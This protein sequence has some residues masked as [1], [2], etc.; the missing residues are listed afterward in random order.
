MI[1][2]H[3]HV[4]FGLD[5]G[6]RDLEMSLQMLRALCEDGVHTV[7]CTPHVR[8]DYPTSA[9]EMEEVVAVV[10]DAAAAESLNITV[11]TG[12]ELSLERLPQLHTRERAR[13][14]LGGNPSLLLLETP[15]LVWPP[16]FPRVCARLAYEGVVPLVA[17][18]ERNP[19]VQEDPALVERVVEAG[20]MTQLTA[21]SVAGD[22]GRRTAACAHRLIE[23]ELVHVVASDSHGV[24]PRDTRMSAARKAVGS[25]ALG[26]WLTEFV[27]AALLAG[28]PIPPRPPSSRRLRSLS[29]VGAHRKLRPGRGQ[30]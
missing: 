12:G 19:M 18:P 30:R 25:G 16:D 10:R 29:R 8:D 20:G 22:F 28:D 9:A 13:L 27:P 3:S 1:D 26:A 14:G 21:A 24:S 6:S 2:L 17:H 5:D 7:C 11:L 23:L 4:A 15:Y